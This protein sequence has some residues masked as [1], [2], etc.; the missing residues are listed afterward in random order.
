[1]FTGLPLEKMGFIL[2]MLQKFL[3]YRT[4]S[5]KILK[6]DYLEDLRGYTKTIL[7][8]DITDAYDKQFQT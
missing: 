8:Y 7:N 6:A 4:A 5:Q 3:T 1:M 2:V